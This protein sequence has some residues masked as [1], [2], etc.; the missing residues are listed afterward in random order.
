MTEA[1]KKKNS[2]RLLLCVCVYERSSFQNDN[3]HLQYRITDNNKKNIRT[4]MQA[5]RGI[6]T[7]K[8]Q[9][10]SLVWHVYTADCAMC[11]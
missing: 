4:H 2:W 6:Y 1:Y 3:G 8:W 5:R 9:P 10:I 7:Q 11:E